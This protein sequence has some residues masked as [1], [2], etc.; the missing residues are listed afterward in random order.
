MER[1]KGKSVAEDKLDLAARLRGTARYPSY[2]QSGNFFS[3]SSG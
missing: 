1:A 3:T 2:L